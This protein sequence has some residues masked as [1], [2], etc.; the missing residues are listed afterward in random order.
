MRAKL[1]ESFLDKPEEYHACEDFWE[2]LVL[3]LQAKLGEGGKWLHHWMCRHYGNGTPR[4]D[5]NPIFSSR[6]ID[7]S[8][9]IRIIQAPWEDEEE[10][11]AAEITEEK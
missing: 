2:K 9:S 11:F 4:L 6:A 10:F 5:G 1:F 3:S 8:R 7:N